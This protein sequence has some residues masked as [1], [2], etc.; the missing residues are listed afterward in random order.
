MYQ[1]TRTF[2]VNS[3]KDSSGVAKWTF[4]TDFFNF[5]RSLKFLK[6][7]VTGIYKRAY[8]EPKMA[9]AQIKLNDL[10]AGQ[11]R[12]KLYIRLSGSMNS[13]YSNA[14]VFKG[15]PLYIEF[16]VTSSDNAETIAKKIAAQVKKF[17][18]MY[19]IKWVTVLPAVD[20]IV[21]NATDE[22]QQ[23]NEANIE[24]LEDTTSSVNR[25]Y[26][27][28]KSAKV[29]TDPEFDGTNLIVQGAEGFGTW[30]MLTKNLHL[31]TYENSRFANMNE[32]ERPIMGAKYNQYI[33][34]Y[35]VNRGQV[36]G[37]GAVGQEVTSLTT[38]VFYVNTLYAESF[39]AG[40][41]ELGTVNEVNNTPYF[42]NL[43]GYKITNEEEWK[44]YV[45]AEYKALYPYDSDIES[46][47]WLVFTYNRIG[48][49]ELVIKHSESPV[50]FSNIPASL[51]IVQSGN[52][53]LLITNTNNFCMFKTNEDLG[54]SDASTGKIEAIFTQDSK[55]Y[56][57]VVQES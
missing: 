36:A 18:S 44:Q 25:E 11:Y 9:M 45:P 57:V 38:H 54:I 27:V 41:K 14:F 13:Y 49:V 1:F 30:M 39:E 24:K 46:D 52:K 3:D 56:S 42:M 20:T 17:Q 12:L 6:A 21:I 55:D 5:R 48:N 19:D 8:S 23:F 26:V 34:N 15:K 10:T 31:P 4:G 51:G 35:K 32:D 43:K 16:E 53:K 28:V 37:A 7:N 33:I 40:L 2:I 29:A 47:P 50:T 22:Y